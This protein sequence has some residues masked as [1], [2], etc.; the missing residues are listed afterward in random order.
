MSKLRVAIVGATG[1]VGQ[2]MLAVLES[3]RFPLTDLV[4]LA[5][6][7]SAGK[8]LTFNGES[9]EVR[10]LDRDSFQGVD[11]ALFS[12]GASISKEMAPAAVSAGA[13]VVDNSSA[14]RMDPDIPLVVP[15]VNP[16]MIATHR[17]IIANP[18][19][20]TIILVVA[21]TPIHRLSPIQRLVASPYQAASGAGA[22]GMD[23]L[24]REAGGEGSASAGSPRNTKA[25]GSPFPHRLAGNLIPR[26][27]TVGD[28]G[29]TREEMKM[30][31]ETRKIM[32]LPPIPI[33]ATC[34]RVPVERA[35]SESV[36]V[37]T[38]RPLSLEEIRDA[39][40]RAPGVTVAD[41]PG[42]DVYPM[43]LVAS[44]EDDVF[45]GRIRKHPFDPATYDL[46][47]VG[48]QIRKGAALNAVQIAE[49][50]FG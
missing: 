12:A 30:V 33:S 20:S 18:N 22:K 10:V 13:V 44:G 3:R 16:E 17:G 14:F 37:T 4:L 25:A 50:L 26:I 47:I 45:V 21:I 49:K 38:A 2:E 35:H 6:G 46:W 43:P 48:D 9:I 23:A 32:S 40:E 11:L 15:E 31:L 42:D 28:N 34:V 36:Q 39:L 7:R 19:C 24:L 1:A 41:A 27:D 5:S 8:K 29:Y